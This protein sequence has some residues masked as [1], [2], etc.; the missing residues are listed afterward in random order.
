MTNEELKIILDEHIEYFI[1]EEHFEAKWKRGESLTADEV[2]NM[3]INNGNEVSPYYL[4]SYKTLEEAK[5][6]LNDYIP[7]VGTRTA[8][9]TDGRYILGDV[10]Y[11][12]SASVDEND[13]VSFI[14]DIWDYIAQGIEV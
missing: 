2:F 4:E 3:A 13:M 12:V 9:L 1:C 7:C 5:E 11:I 10:V 6:K 14:T 8:N